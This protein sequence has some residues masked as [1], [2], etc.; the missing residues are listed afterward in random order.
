MGI[1]SMLEEEC[2]IPKGS[3]DGFASKL[4]ENHLGKSPKFGRPKP[5]KKA[6]AVEHF[7]IEHYA[8]NVG[9]FRN[10]LLELSSTGLL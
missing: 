3:D 4:L 9:I 10:I 2:M 7:F 6:L 8:G 5:N 1:L